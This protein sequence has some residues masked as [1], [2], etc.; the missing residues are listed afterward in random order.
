MNVLELRLITKQ[1]SVED[2]AAIYETWRTARLPRA[3]RLFSQVL[4]AVAQF[5]KVSLVAN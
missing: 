5:E 2:A 1:T 4:G 3:A